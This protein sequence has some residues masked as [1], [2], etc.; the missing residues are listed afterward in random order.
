MTFVYNRSKIGFP[1]ELLLTNLLVYT[2]ANNVYFRKSTPLVV[3]KNQIL[4]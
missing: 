1:C 2:D 3:S 4:Q